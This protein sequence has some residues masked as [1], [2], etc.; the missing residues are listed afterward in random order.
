CRSGAPTMSDSPSQQGVGD[1]ARPVELDND[2]AVPEPGEPR[3]PHQTSAV[4]SVYCPC[5]SV[6]SQRRISRCTSPAPTIGSDG[7]SQPRGASTNARDCVPPR[8][9]CEPTSS[10]NAATSPVSGQ[11]AELTMRSA[12][13]SNPSVRR[14]WSAAFGPNGASGSSPSTRRS[15]RKF[16][17]CGPRATA[18]WASERTKTKPMPGCEQSVGTT[19]G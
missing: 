9:P 6:A 18:P 19:A 2:R 4:T 17:P 14:T 16:V 5:P 15:S 10:S 7:T 13:W 11:Y 8:P 12:Q 1:D 3:R